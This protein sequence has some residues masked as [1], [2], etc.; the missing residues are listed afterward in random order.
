[1][2]WIVDTYAS[3][4]P[5][6]IDAAGCVTGKPVTQVVYADVKKPPA[7]VFSLVSREVCNMEDVMGKLGL[8]TGIEGRKW[9]FQIR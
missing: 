7:S 5:G 9:W 6:E 3:L 1:M 4:K 8:K 2:A